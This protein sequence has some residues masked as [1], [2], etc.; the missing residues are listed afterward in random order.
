MR[1]CSEFNVEAFDTRGE[2][3]LKSDSRLRDPIVLCQ[4]LDQAVVGGAI[5]GPLLKKHGQTSVI[6]GLN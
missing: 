3:G 5:N 1:F 2:P 6:T 4:H